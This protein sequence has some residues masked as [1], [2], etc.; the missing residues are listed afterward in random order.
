MALTAI[1]PIFQD[2]E[3]AT[4][5]GLRVWRIESLRPVRIADE[6]IGKFFSGDAYLV[7]HSVLTDKYKKLDHCIFYWIGSECSIDER[8]AL[9][10]KARELDDALAGAAVQYREVEGHESPQFI[11]SFRDRSLQFLKG[12]ID[13]AFRSVDTNQF[14]EAHTL[15]M[16]KGVHIPL[17]SQVTPVARSQLSS[18]DVFVLDAPSLKKIWIF[19]GETSS[20]YEKHAGRKFA[21]S[22]NSGERVGKCTIEVVTADEKD[23]EFWK[24]VAGGFGPIP[25]PQMDDSSY[26]RQLTTALY[27]I[28]NDLV[29]LMPVSQGVDQAALD[30]GH[31]FLLDCGSELFMWLGRNAPKQLRAAAA[32][33]V[34]ADF[35]AREN[36]PSHTRISCI[37]EDY[38][39]ALFKS[40]FPSWKVPS[41][42]QLADKPQPAQAK[43][44]DDPVKRMQQ[45]RLSADKDATAE[46]D[47]TVESMTVHRIKDFEKEPI[48]SASY[49]LFFSGDAYIISVS[50]RRNGRSRL[51]HTVYFWQGRDCS[52][53]ERGASAILAADIARTSFSNA[54]VVRIVEGKE[55]FHFT[56]L[57]GGKFLVVRGGV[58]SAFHHVG[59][60]ASSGSSV[61]QYDAKED[62]LIMIHGSPR[63]GVRAFQMPLDGANL[64][65][66]NAF[67]LQTSSRLSL[68]IGKY[69]NDDERHGALT[70]AVFVNSLA[71]KQRPIVEMDEG[72]EDDE[73]WSAF[74]GGHTTDYNTMCDPEEE[75]IAPRLFWCRWVGK[76][77]VEEI[78]QFSQAD[79]HHDDCYLLDAHHSLYLWIGRDSSPNEIEECSKL[80][81]EYLARSRSADQPTDTGITS[82]A[83][84]FEPRFFTMFFPD[85]RIADPTQTE[86]VASEQ[87]VPTPASASQPAAFISSPP[88]S[89]KPPVSSSSSTSITSVAATPV[90]SK[91]S[92]V[93]PPTA[94]KPTTAPSTASASPVP[95]TSQENVATAASGGR[96]FPYSQLR[97]DSGMPLPEEVDPAA[98]QDFLSTEEFQNV[99]GM[100]RAQFSELKLWRQNGLK[101]EK[102]LF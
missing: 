94:E 52:V 53:D 66:A 50:F 6:Q 90:A 31:C 26:S 74:P 3:L 25:V 83:D 65:S 56:S 42:R 38:E 60:A 21:E 37:H 79:L 89:T 16:V 20:M 84:G 99:F 61:Q 12:G 23:S 48:D 14:K 68:W 24:Q 86:V 13:S 41:H 97:V 10:I 28:A 85:W 18:G 67:L 58:D 100:S 1:D 44:V 82:V 33:D 70:V 72:H 101:K 98:R 34:P 29:S 40:K 92:P 17:I 77:L 81:R 102:H 47:M 36:R 78:T 73:F 46:V 59:T 55:P 35:L 75:E 87:S 7:L 43:V 30:S 95:V 88:A 62:A 57:F 49:G 8:G 9:A 91:Q 11:G 19:Q 45:Q 80:A 2:S 54:S 64:S 71:D 63:T 15:Y 76:L 5:P 93:D 4:K 32:Y 96:I 39:S 22:L 69:A 27:V 51:E